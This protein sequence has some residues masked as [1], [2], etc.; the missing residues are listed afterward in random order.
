MFYKWLYNRIHVLHLGIF[1]IFVKVTTFWQCRTKNQSNS[2]VF[3]TCK[4]PQNTR[5]TM[6]LI[7]YHKKTGNHDDWKYDDK[8]KGH[9]NN[10]RFDLADMNVFWD[11][12]CCVVPNLVAFQR[13]TFTCFVCLR[14]VLNARMSSTRNTIG[15][16]YPGWN[17]KN[18]GRA[19]RAESD[20]I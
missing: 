11:K 9:S 12:V 15:L 10:P 19:A 8:E 6:I 16:G 17:I 3:A 5:E 14:I 18:V 20:Y 1:Q 4:P 2:N 13:I 7:T